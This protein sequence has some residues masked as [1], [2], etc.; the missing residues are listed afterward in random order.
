MFRVRLVA[1]P[2]AALVAALIPL[3]SVAP[4]AAP[5]SRPTLAQYLEPGMPVELVSAAAADRIAWTAY[6]EGKRNVFTAVGPAYAPVRV[7]SFLKDDGIDLTDLRISA[8]GST[9]AFVRG[10]SPNNQ[11]WVA[12]VASDPNG[13]E[14]AIWVAHT[15][16]PGS[17]TRVAESQERQFA[18]ELSP[19][20][21]YVVYVKEGQIYRARVTPGAGASAIDKGEKPF[22]DIWGA[23]SGPKWSPDSSKIAFVSN[24]T[25]H[26]FIAVYEM[27]TRT[28]H[29]LSPSTDRD[30]SP[31][32]SADSK[33]VAFLRRPGLPFGQQATPGQDA[34]LPPTAAG[35]GGNGGGRGAVPPP[36]SAVA[37]ATGATVPGQGSAPGGG[38]GGRGGRNGG[39][40]AAAGEPQA[41]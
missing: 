7:T 16:V 12:D 31:T 6:E 23:N 24:R 1:V 36:S 40:G 39:N 13:G 26:S 2:V 28:V 17:A 14:R 5:T 15:N 37:G 10:T 9:V 32:W 35:R 20:G 41:G 29:Y 11:G 38:R 3:A 22:I 27:K 19:D 21:Q 33:R 30:T 18:P 25:D 4:S 34:G 8:D